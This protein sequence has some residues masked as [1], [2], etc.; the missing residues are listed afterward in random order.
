LPEGHGNPAR[1]IGRYREQGRERFLTSDEMVRLGAVLVEGETIGLPYEVD[2][3]KPTAKH[4]PKADKRR[5]KLDL[6]A[7]AAIRLLILTGARL[8]EILL[9][10]WEHVDF[11][12]GMIFL[13]DSKTGR[14]RV[15]LSAA[16]L[17][18]LAS[19][20]RIEDNPFV[21]PGTKPSRA[22]T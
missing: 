10:K 8:R 18:I 7:I 11:E 21:I 5:V 9:S 2:D 3:T 16:S 12:C 22:R 13:P 6:F 15:Y 4:A 19:L 17:A 1:K 20:P 14:K